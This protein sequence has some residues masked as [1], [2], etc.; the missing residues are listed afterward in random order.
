MFPNLK[1][2]EDKFLNAHIHEDPA[3]SSD[4]SKLT[5]EILIESKQ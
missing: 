4:I 5:E 1:L 3:L 2:G